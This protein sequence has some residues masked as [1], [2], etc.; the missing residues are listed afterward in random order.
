MVDPEHWSVIIV[1]DEPDNLGVIELVLSFN[2]VDFRVA[3]SGEAC[4]R[5]LDEKVPTFLLVD[6]QMPEMSGYELLERIRANS[7][8]TFLPVIA[9]TAYAQPEDEAKIALVGFD[10]H[11]SKP[12]D[13][14]TLMDEIREIL[15]RKGGG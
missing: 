15:D 7:D 3:L 10:G 5:L 6:I 1:D 9:V 11:I 12:V 14:L 2:N 8:W 4:L 13:V